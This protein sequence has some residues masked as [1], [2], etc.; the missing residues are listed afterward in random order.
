MRIKSLLE[1]H[2]N[3]IFCGDFFSCLSHV[4]LMFP[5][6]FILTCNHRRTEDFTMEGVH[7]VGPDLG[8]CWDGSRA[9]GSMGKASVEGQGTK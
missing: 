4:K 1:H 2:V 5:Q 9:V 6:Y 8:V 3:H 7:V